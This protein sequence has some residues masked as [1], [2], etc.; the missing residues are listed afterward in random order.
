[1]GEKKKEKARA[2]SDPFIHPYLSVLSARNQ[3]KK[4]HDFMDRNRNP[5]VDGVLP[6]NHSSL[7]FQKKTFY[8]KE[9]EIYI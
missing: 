4:R 1:M 6:F 2:P 8:V 5:I 3:K 9:K 7:T